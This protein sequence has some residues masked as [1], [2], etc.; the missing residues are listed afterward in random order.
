MRW[1]WIGIAL[2]LI[3]LIL[4]GVFVPFPVHAQ[5]P[6]ITLD[7]TATGDDG[8]VGTAATQ[9]IRWRNVLPDT[10]GMGLWLAPV[11]A[12]GQNGNIAT[13][14]TALKTWWNAANR[15]TTMPVPKIAGSAESFA[16]NGAFATGSSYYFILQVC[17]EAANC[18][19]SNLAVKLLPDTTP[20][21][22][23]LDFRAR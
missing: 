4:I 23:I 15:V 8:N 13:M 6:S 14:P 16:V 20:P 3:A 21:A 12:G 9:E 18:V 10:T 1:G 5:V 11:A 22:P 17:D 7:W 2:G 19:G